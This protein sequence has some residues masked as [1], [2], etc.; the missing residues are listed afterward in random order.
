MSEE[1]SKEKAI[2]AIK[3][4]YKDLDLTEEEQGALEGDLKEL[5][6]MINKL[7][8]DHIEIAVFGEVSA[9][10]SSLL[11]ALLGEK[12]FEVGARNG[13][14]TMR[15]KKEWDVIKHSSGS[16]GRVILVD[17]PGINEVDGSERT[18]VAET[19]IKDSD[20]VLFVVKGDMNDTEYE[21]IKMLH[22]FNKPILVAFNKAD[23]FSSKQRA[24]VL[25]ALHEKLDG[26]VL[27]ENIVLTSGDPNEREVIIEKPDGSEETVMKKPAPLLDDLKLRILEILE[28]DG[29]EM[30]AIN[31]GLYASGIS[32]KI[33][34]KKVQYR[35]KFADNLINKFSFYKGLAVALNP[36]PI[37]DMVGGV[38]VDGVMVIQIGK[39]YGEEMG[40]IPS[41]D[42][43]GKI[44]YSQLSLWGIEG[45]THLIAGTA[46]T[47][48]LGVGNI[49]LGVPQG[50]I[51]SWGTKI[52]GEACHYYFANNKSWGEKG[53]KTVVSEIMNHTDRKSIMNNMKFQIEEALKN[54]GLKEK[55]M[56][57][58][59]DMKKAN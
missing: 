9:G 56:K 55:I 19:T 51:A 44:A 4:I 47:A 29:K 34:T 5:Q 10:K 12:A 24:E 54:K 40:L 3:N 6:D 18:E 23:V 50:M 26:I 1:D 2:D 49:V 8:S 35:K 53:V 25:S 45:I 13:V 28:K 21:A 37:A 31:A 22:S 17:T 32:D 27:P 36:F 58:I 16:D 14:T 11:N 38:V 52:I 46:E 43:A 57:E 7:E 20:M 41:Q 33:A 42:L 59:K 48:T 30:V 39:V 15:G